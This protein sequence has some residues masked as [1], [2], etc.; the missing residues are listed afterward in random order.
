MVGYLIY[1]SRSMPERLAKIVSSVLGFLVVALSSLLVPSSGVVGEAF[2]QPRPGNS[3]SSFAIMAVS[4]LGLYVVL[5]A[6]RRWL[7]A[8]GASASLE[9]FVIF[10]LSAALAASIPLMVRLA[11]DSVQVTGSM[12]LLILSGGLFGGLAYLLRA[13]LD[14][15]LTEGDARGRVGTSVAYPGRGSAALSGDPPRPDRSRAGT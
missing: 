10:V 14:T 1:T 4:A 2:F 15:A 8:P 7:M 5:A 6:F 11:T 13:L 12:A 9:A 3:L